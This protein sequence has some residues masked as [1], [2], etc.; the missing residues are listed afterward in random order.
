V[1]EPI[2]DYD[3][4][5]GRVPEVSSD[6]RPQSGLREKIDELG[7]TVHEQFGARFSDPQTIE[8]KNGLRLH[9][10]LC[11]STLV[12]RLGIQDARHRKS[13]QEG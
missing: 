9:W 7:V 5:R 11:C 10:S 12:A 2:L 1:S 4:L 13:G 3:R 8:A 6:V